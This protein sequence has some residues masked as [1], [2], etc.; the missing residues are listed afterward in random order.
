MQNNWLF[1]ASD[2]ALQVNPWQSTMNDFPYWFWFFILFVNI[3]HFQYWSSILT[4]WKWIFLCENFWDGI[5]SGNW[6]LMLFKIIKR[7]EK[8][9]QVIRMLSGQT[10]RS[11]LNPAFWE[12][13]K[14]W[15]HWENTCRAVHYKL[16]VCSKT[17]WRNRMQAWLQI[18]LRNTIGELRELGSRISPSSVS[19]KT[20]TSHALLVFSIE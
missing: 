6:Q 7:Q 4:Q 9:N 3:H 20:G 10:H 2:P 19:R 14:R 18:P 1:S 13:L 8:D 15:Q 12:I 5:Q 17:P 11:R 16:G